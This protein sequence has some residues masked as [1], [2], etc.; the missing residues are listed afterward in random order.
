MVHCCFSTCNKVPSVGKSIGILF[1]L[2]LLGDVLANL[3]GEGLTLLPRHLSLNVP[4][5]LH[6]RQDNVR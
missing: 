4:T 3:L 5:V 2:D 1:G 6:L